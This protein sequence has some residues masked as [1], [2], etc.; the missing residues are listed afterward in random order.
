MTNPDKAVNFGHFHPEVTEDTVIISR[1]DRRAV[2]G[3]LKAIISEGF[4]DADAIPKP[5]ARGITKLTPELAGYTALGMGS[6]AE[7][8]ADPRRRSFLE[9]RALSLGQASLQAGLVQEPPLSQVD[10][11]LH[12]ELTDMVQELHALHPQPQD[13]TDL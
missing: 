3:V 7:S 11:E 5:D 12:F 1:W 6:F 8:E 10:P 13:T 9:R 4:L 2:T